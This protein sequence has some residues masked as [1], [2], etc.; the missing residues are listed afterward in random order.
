MRSVSGTEAWRKFVFV[1]VC[2]CVCLLVFRCASLMISGRGV[3][4]A[5]LEELDTC[6]HTL[7][8]HDPCA[9]AQSRG[10]VRRDMRSRQAANARTE[11][12]QHRRNVGRNVHD[13][14]ALLSACDV[15]GCVVVMYMLLCF[16]DV[17]VVCC[18]IGCAF[19]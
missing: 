2:L 15:C 3:C 19:V 11:A 10:V 9:A 4:R 12:P 8:Q 7:T 17:C 1:I 16:C 6:T 5:S 13:D 18:V 14:R